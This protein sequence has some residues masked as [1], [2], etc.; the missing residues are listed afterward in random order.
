MDNVIQFPE[1]IRITD[2]MAEKAM[3]CAARQHAG[4][5]VGRLHGTPTRDDLDE[6]LVQLDEAKAII[7]SLLVMP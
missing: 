3:L 7:L 4:S 2:F 6:A 5:A 1:Q